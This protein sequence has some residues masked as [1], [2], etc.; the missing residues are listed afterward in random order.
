M[1]KDRGSVGSSGSVGAWRAG[2]DIS[3]KDLDTG[4]VCSSPGSE[5]WKERSDSALSI[6]ME[7][8]WAAFKTPHNDTGH[9]AG[10]L[11]RAQLH[12][13]CTLRRWV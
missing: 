1:A 4:W 9:I 2:K 13:C 7:G 8:G 5:F 3:K 11:L 10:L 12:G 6:H